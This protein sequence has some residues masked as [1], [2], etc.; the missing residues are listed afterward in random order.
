MTTAPVI[1]SAIETTPQASGGAGTD[2]MR[3]G[4]PGDHRELGL[5]LR[6]QATG[7]G[8]IRRIPRQFAVSH[9]NLPKIPRES[10]KVREKLSKIPRRFSKIPKVSQLLEP[11]H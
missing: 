2:S 4:P 3:I 11:A 6:S 1:N 5:P 7:A 8:R 9:A 10:P